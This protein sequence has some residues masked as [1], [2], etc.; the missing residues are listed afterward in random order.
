MQPASHLLGFLL[1]V[2]SKLSR[3]QLSDCVAIEALGLSPLKGAVFSLKLVIALEGHGNLGL[4]RLFPV[5]CLVSA[6]CSS[7]RTVDL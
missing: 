5:I 7:F 1:F 3:H 4:V 2:L 6:S